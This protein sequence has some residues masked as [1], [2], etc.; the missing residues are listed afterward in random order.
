MAT[1]KKLTPQQQ[2]DRRAK[3]M[4][5]VLGVAFVGIMALQ[6]PK[7]L[8]GSGG[9]TPAAAPA[10]TVAAGAVGLAAA[11]TPNQ[12]TSFSHFPHKD[13]F[14]PGVKLAA[15][16]GATATPG[17]VTT[18]VKP[19]RAPKT[20]PAP[21]V[22]FSVQ[23]QSTTPSGPLVPAVLL[24]VNGKKEVL[25]IGAVFPA[26]APVFKLTAI[27]ADAIWLKLIGGS[28]ANGNQ[29]L[30]VMRGHPVK[31]VNDTVGMHFAL[32]LIKLTTAPPPPPP[33]P[34]PA[35]ATPAATTTTSTSSTTTSG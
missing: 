17:A 8:K 27:S 23:P 34:A 21:Q 33:L 5:G 29:T 2:R 6:L 11:S 28:F 26:K 14:H 12:L 9:G 32:V 1:K 7:I 13:P 19:A 4:L 22:K 35:P 24:R 3:M 30:K 16:A 25:P 31:L 10:S 20:K 15:A 18:G